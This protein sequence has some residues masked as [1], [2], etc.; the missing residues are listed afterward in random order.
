MPQ[1]DQQL[2]K[3]APG[4]RQRVNWNMKNRYV[5]NYYIMKLEMKRMTRDGDK[6]LYQEGTREGRDSERRREHVA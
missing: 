1:S 2:G 5:L 4:G 3:G 6:R